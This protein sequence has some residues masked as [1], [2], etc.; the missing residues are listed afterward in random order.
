M[1]LYGVELFNKQE[2]T[3]KYSRKKT[4]ISRRFPTQRSE[5][6]NSQSE[7]FNRKSDKPNFQS[8]K[9]NL[10]GNLQLAVGKT[11]LSD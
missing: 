10:V 9:Y 3:Y 1:Y 11:Q 5:K 7:I 2:V 6:H 4:I 8:E